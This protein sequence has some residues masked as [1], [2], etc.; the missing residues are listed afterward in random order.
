MSKFSSSVAQSQGERSVDL[1]PSDLIAS[2]TTCSP[3][4]VIHM[5]FARTKWTTSSS[6]HTVLL[7]RLE[8][9]PGSSTFYDNALEISQE[10]MTAWTSCYE[11][12]QVHMYCLQHFAVTHLQFVAFPYYLFIRNALRSEDVMKVSIRGPAYF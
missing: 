7:A 8:F 1:V 10:F 3:M 6:R 2:E 4:K 12:P 11:W 9:L 5:V